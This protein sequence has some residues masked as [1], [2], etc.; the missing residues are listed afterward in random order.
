MIANRTGVRTAEVNAVFAG[1]ESPRPGTGR[2]PRFEPR[3][4][5]SVRQSNDRVRAF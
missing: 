5:R 1:G 4:L 3:R 2:V